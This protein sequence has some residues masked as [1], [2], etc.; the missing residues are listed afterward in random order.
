VSIDWDNQETPVQAF[1]RKMP[2]KGETVMGEDG[3]GTPCW[4]GG[5]LLSIFHTD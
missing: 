3:G 4:I 2:P 5:E 1:A